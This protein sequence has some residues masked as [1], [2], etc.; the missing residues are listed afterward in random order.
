MYKY[1][2]KRYIVSKDKKYCFLDFLKD[3]TDLITVQVDEN[4]YNACE[5]QMGDVVPD[6]SIGVRYYK[7]GFDYI[8]R[9]TFK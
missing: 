8:A 7:K 5:L 3:D 1:V 6:D 9:F 4:L 2:T